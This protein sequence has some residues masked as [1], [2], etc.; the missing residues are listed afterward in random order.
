[1]S[2]ETITTNDSPIVA[3][4]AATSRTLYLGFCGVIDAAGVAKIAG[5]FNQGVND[6][7]EAVHLTFS[8]PGGMAADGVFLYHHIRSLPIQTIIHNTG[9][10][11][12]VATTIFAAADVR[13]ACD[14]S[15]FMI[16]PVQAQANGAHAS[17]QSSLD[18]A[19]AEEARIDQILTERT[20]I[21]KSVLDQRRS[22][23]IFFPANKAL[24]Y[25][26][27]HDIGAFTLPPGNK[28]FH[29]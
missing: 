9:M 3:I 12:S 27:V 2:Q 18:M 4:S 26:L 10:V 25:G 7:Y 5:A 16:H 13:R 17:L 21:P 14:N 24:E 1:M 15:I 20:N 23:E 19:L 6:G 29:L 11:A 22:L 28:V 8:S